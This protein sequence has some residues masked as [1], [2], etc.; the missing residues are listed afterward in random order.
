MIPTTPTPTKHP[1]LHFWKNFF[2]GSPLGP[3]TFLS[4]TFSFKQIQHF[5]YL[6]PFD[7]S[8]VE[9]LQRMCLIWDVASWSDYRSGWSCPEPPDIFL[10]VVKRADTYQQRRPI[11]SSSQ[12]AL[13]DRYRK[14]YRTL[15]NAKK[16]FNSI[17]NSKK[18]QPYSFKILF[19]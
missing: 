2:Y 3:I 13:G 19:I 10:T 17:F 16:P 18:F 14:F 15:N 11:D 12:L 5:V 8:S 1:L 7:P 4:S 9:F 6:K